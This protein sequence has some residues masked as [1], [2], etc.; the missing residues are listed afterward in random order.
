MH[1]C[2]EC[3]GVCY[4]KLMPDETVASNEQLDGIQLHGCKL[5]ASEDNESTV[6]EKEHH[7]EEVVPVPGNQQLSQSPLSEMPAGRMLT[8]IQEE[9]ESREEEALKGV[10]SQWKIE[11][12]TGQTFNFHFLVALR[13]WIMDG[14]ISVGDSIMTSAGEVYAVEQYPGTADLFSNLEVMQQR[15]QEVLANKRRRQQNRL[16][17]QKFK[18][19]HVEMS[20]VAC[21]FALV[22]LFGVH[23]GWQ[24]YELRSSIKKADN[25]LSGIYRIGLSDNIVEDFDVV[26]RMLWEKRS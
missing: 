5:M 7:E 14:R 8:W 2:N 6:V 16:S 4:V 17:W 22:L 3:G 20:L 10:V 12:T 1:S 21:T 11:R 13:K 9:A 15:R 26:E 18:K 25:Y 24:H 23:L 19:R